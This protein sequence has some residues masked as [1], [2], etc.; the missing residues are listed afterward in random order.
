MDPQKATEAQRHGGKTWTRINADQSRFGYT[1]L[2][3]Q[4]PVQKRTV[5]RD[6]RPSIQVHL[7][8][9]LP[10]CIS[11]PSC[12]VSSLA[13]GRVPI[14]VCGRPIFCSVSL[15]LCGAYLISFIPERLNGIQSGSFV[16]G[17]IA[18]EDAYGAGKNNR[19]KNGTGRDQCRPT[20]E[21]GNA[22]RTCDSQCQ[23]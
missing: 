1:F 7:L 9:L 5:N 15:C 17:I 20:Q 6:I 4:A 3:V 14:G 18:K 16:G 22:Y 21:L 19:Y 12:L 23:P 10:S 2:G 8:I 13:F 11:C